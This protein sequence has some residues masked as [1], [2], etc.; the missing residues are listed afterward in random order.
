MQQ[1][2]KRK[3]GAF[4]SRWRNRWFFCSSSDTKSAVK[5]FKLICE[6][7]REIFLMR[8]LG[9]FSPGLKSRF[10]TVLPSQALIQGQTQSFLRSMHFFSPLV[11]RGFT[12]AGSFFQSVFD[13]PPF[14]AALRYMRY[15]A[16]YFSK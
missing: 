11:S 2:H 10:I 13:C 5:L 8:N 6:I 14:V 7:P 9:S 3:K 1:G 4:N 12:A 15:T 16:L